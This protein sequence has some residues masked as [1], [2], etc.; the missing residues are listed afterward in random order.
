VGV[1]PLKMGMH[2]EGF[3]CAFD[4]YKFWLYFGEIISPLAYAMLQTCFQHIS[5]CST[6]I[7]EPKII[8]MPKH[9]F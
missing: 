8:I 6:F 4:S 7:W 1:Q 3:K 2:I 5:F 9:G